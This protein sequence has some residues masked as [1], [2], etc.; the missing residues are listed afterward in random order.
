MLAPSRSFA[1]SPL[2]ELCLEV[3]RI[4]GA[5][6]LDYDGVTARLRERALEPVT[7]DPPR[8]V[9]GDAVQIMTIHQAK[10]LEFPIVAWWDGHAKLAPRDRQGAWFVARDGAAWAMA[11]D[12]L[13]WAEPAGG[14]LLDRELAYLGA[15][16]LRL[17]YVAAT[18]ARDLLVLPRSGGLRQAGITPALIGP[19]DAPAVV[20]LEPFTDVGAPNWARRAVP[21]PP[22][23]PKTAKARS[24]E[25][26][27]EWADASAEAGRPRFVPKGV[28]TE[29]HR[30]ADEEREGDAGEWW[31]SRKGRF[32]SVFGE[33]VHTAIGLALGDP[34]LDPASAVA[35]AAQATGLGE[36]R[37][38]AAQDVERALAALAKEGL[39]ELPGDA[40]RLEYPVAQGRDGLLLVGYIDLLAARA[41]GLQLIDF[42]TDA[43]P[44]ADVTKSHPDY[45]EQ[46]RSYARIL[47]ELGLAREG[48]VRCGLL[49]TA[50]GGL[51]WV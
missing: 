5:E 26:A 19:P 28:S 16:R 1:R 13:S 51:R 12:G 45:V 39:R 44:A 17:V 29:A 38:Q 23:A 22:R 24:E 35:K 46:V 7:I 9:G 40:L 18:R 6:G 37:S 3:E 31:K 32:G 10:G 36:H 15:E 43:P 27:R 21:L 25:V 30:V 8:P 2:R 47:V 42:K 20:T 34:M 33:T 50:D 14:D 49:F 11:L 48:A 41:G 4:A